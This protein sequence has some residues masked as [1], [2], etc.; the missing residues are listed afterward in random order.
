MGKMGLSMCFQRCWLDW[1]QP[2]TCSLFVPGPSGVIVGAKTTEY[3]LEKSRIVGQAK[4]ERNY[5]VFY[6]LLQGLPPEERDAYG[7]TKVEDYQYLNQ[8]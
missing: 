7:L 3:L 5:H 6:Q 1:I 4:G 8:V 2:E